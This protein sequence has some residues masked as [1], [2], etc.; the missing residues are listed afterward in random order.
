MDIYT[1]DDQFR[2]KDIVDRFE[3]M[4]WT[5]RFSTS[6]EFELSIQ[7]TRDTRALFAVDTNI[8]INSSKRCMTV[9]NVEKTIG[10][11]GSNLL[12]I[13][14]P[15]LEEI[16]KDRVAKESMTPLTNI[17]VG[18]AT[19]TIASPVVVTRANHGFVTGA[20][21][22]FTTTGALPTGVV[23]STAYYV[24]LVNANTFRLATSYDN[25]IAGT[26]MNTSG[27]Q[28]GTH[29]L[30][31]ITNGKWKLTGPPADILRY[32]FQHVCV[33]GA[34]SP[35]DVIP[36]IHNGS[37]YDPNTIPEPDDDITIEVSP[38]SVFDVIEQLC[39]VYDLGFRL[40][41]DYDTS[42]LY[43]EIYSGNDRTTL[44]SVLPPVIFSP[45]LDNLTNTNEFVS[46]AGNKNVAYVFSGAGFEVVYASGTDSS[47]SGMNRR[48][49]TVIA[50]D[51][52]LP[53]GAALTAALQQRGIEE[54]AKYKTLVA[55]DGETSEYSP[56]VYDQHF[57][58]GDLVEMRSDDGITNNMRVTEQIIVSDAQGERSYPTLAIDTIITPGSWYAWD[59][60]QVWD[61]ATEV[62]DDA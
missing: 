52:D 53:I 2:R 6:G 21:V 5:E 24:I 14:G 3:S 8:A 56:Y 49:L 41:R 48:V 18:T 61:D 16:L 38:S 26:A 7:D 34:L 28:S 22:F 60:G 36:F 30:W 62:W 17:S 19:M 43:F 23:S 20:P 40:T 29:T 47:V 44:Q 27:S 31:K 54:L 37:M 50:D 59:A 9:K 25:A 58:L 46:T 51:I 13:S 32:I 10:A 39:S 45:S 33:T 35:N 55:F 42:K 11:D 57:N 4:I 12:K 1:L 15:S